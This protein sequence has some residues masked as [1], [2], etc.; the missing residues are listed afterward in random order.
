MVYTKWIRRLAAHKFRA[1]PFGGISLRARPRAVRIPA[2]AAASDWAEVRERLHGER[3]ATFN[4]RIGAEH[5]WRE[6]VFNGEGLRLRR[7]RIQRKDEQRK[8]GCN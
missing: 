2:P 7:N 5:E 3:A 4:A 8:A 6:D 1:P